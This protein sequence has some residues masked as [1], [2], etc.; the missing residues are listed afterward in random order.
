[1]AEHLIDH[2]HFFVETLS[3]S[4]M[5]GRNEEQECVHFF[6]WMREMNYSCFC[7]FEKPNHLSLLE[8]DP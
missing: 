6:L 1:M 7:E 2:K 5:M 3:Q 8:L 4:H